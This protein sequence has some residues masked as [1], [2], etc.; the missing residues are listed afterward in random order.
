[1]K[2]PESHSLPPIIS[3]SGI[4][5]AG[6]TRLASALARHFHGVS[7]KQRTG[8]RF[9]KI[10]ASYGDYSWTQPIPQ[11]LGSELSLAYALD[12]RDYAI[13]SVSR[14]DACPSILYDRW[15]LCVRAF[16]KVFAKPCIY[17]ELLKI[18]SNIPK[19]HVTL[20]LD[21]SPHVAYSRIARR[22]AHDKDENIE[23]LTV[24]RKSYLEEAQCTDNVQILDA[25][26][27]F[28]KVFIDAVGLIT[29]RY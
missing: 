19:P 9:N 8:K 26:R 15:D 11:P 28:K 27:D 17:S 14:V 7:R 18:I 22:G 21:V 24:L 29:K 1:M 16:G 2:S 10:L 3:I 6:K 4:D 5:G 13:R 20:L 25:S 23:L 12:F